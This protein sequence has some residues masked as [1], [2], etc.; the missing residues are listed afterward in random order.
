MIVVV[1][2]EWEEWGD[3]DTTKILN[4]D[5]HIKCPHIGTYDVP[6]VVADNRKDSCKGEK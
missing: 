4:E 1:L 6:N 3:V 5:G 2:D